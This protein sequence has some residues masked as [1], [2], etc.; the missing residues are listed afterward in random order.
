MGAKVVEGNFAGSAHMLE[1][2]Q[3]ISQ[4]AGDSPCV[5]NVSLGTN[6]GAHDGKSL[7]E[8]GIDTI[9]HAKSNRAIVLAASNSYADGIHASGTVKQGETFDLNWIVESHDFTFNELELWYDKKDEFS[10]E[11]ITPQGKSLGELKLGTNHQ[12]LGPHNE[13]LAFMAHRKNDPNNGDHVINIFMERSQ[14]NSLDPEHNWVTVGKWMIR[15]KGLRIESGKFHAWIERDDAAQ[16]HFDAPLDNSHTIGSISCGMK[17]V[18]VGSY[19]A[20]APDTPLSF[21]SS[22]GPTRDGRQKPEI[23]APGHRVSAAASGTETGHI[24]MSGTSMAAPAVTGVIA[25]MLAEAHAHGLKLSSDEIHEILRASAR[26]MANGWHDRYGY[27]RIDASEAIKKVE[28]LL[29][30][31]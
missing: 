2:L 13:I 8:T 17:S 23:S 30:V 22:S 12:I 16:S 29:P 24:Q 7:V 19:D 31:R 3:F 11:I 21:F 4:T 10:C 5:M 1:A 28:A 15:L 6:G 18:V 14:M 9:V 25:L 27:G 26:P 20:K